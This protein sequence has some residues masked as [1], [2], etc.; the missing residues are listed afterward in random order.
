MSGNVHKYNDY[1]KKLGNRLPTERFK[2]DFVFRQQ[3]GDTSRHL[4]DDFDG[5]RDEINKVRAGDHGNHLV[6]AAKASNVNNI[7]VKD[8]GTSKATSEKMEA[9]DWAK[10][11]NNARAKGD[12]DVTAR[13]RAFANNFYHAAGKEAASA[14]QHLQVFRS[15]KYMEDR[16]KKCGRRT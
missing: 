1:L 5:T 12:N 3:T 15:C 13:I 11:A 2:V 9:V 10:T 14:R 6:D 7:V 8:F 4:F 16:A